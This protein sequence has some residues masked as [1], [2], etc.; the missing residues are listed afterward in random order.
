MATKETSEATSAT[1]RSAMSMVNPVF[2]ECPTMFDICSWIKT[3]G[4]GC[5][6]T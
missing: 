6:P 3:P 1:M 5:C 2:Y 4:E